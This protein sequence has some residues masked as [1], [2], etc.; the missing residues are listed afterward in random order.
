MTDMRVVSGIQPTGDL[1]LGNL[2]GA[3]RVPSVAVG[4]DRE[5]HR[6]TSYNVC[7]TKLLRFDQIAEG[8]PAGSDKLIF[9]PWLYGE[10]APVDD[11]LVRNNFV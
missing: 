3:I 8:A 11:H 6:I 2:L 4:E 10:R 7:Y 9:T 5:G 1:H